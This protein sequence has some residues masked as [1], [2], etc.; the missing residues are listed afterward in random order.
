MQ[1][2]LFLIYVP[3]DLVKVLIFQT[4]F[5]FCALTNKLLVLGLEFAKY[6]RED[7][8]QTASSEAV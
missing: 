2:S 8:D 5:S 6:F 4:L 7:T 1:T 3:G